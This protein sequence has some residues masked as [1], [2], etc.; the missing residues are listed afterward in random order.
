M[1]SVQQEGAV[2]DGQVVEGEAEVAAAPAEGA[3]TE[4]V[5]AK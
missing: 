2:A 3:A 1:E 4:A 5:E